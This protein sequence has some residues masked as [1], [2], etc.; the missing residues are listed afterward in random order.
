MEQKELIEVAVKIAKKFI[1]PQ[2]GLSLRAYPDPKS[3][4]GKLLTLHGK[5]R[6]YIAGRYVIPENFLKFSPEPVTIGY[7]STFQGLKLGTIWGL[8]EAEKALDSEIAVR[9]GQ[10]IKACPNL[11]KHSPEKLAACVSLQYNIGAQAFKDSTLAKLINKEDMIAA[12]EQFKRWNLVSGEVV[13][14]LVN[15]RAAEKSLFVSVKN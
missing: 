4:L 15:R 1:K 9:V 12:A 7:G 8:D 6:E 11:L 2:E 14:G 10:V 5:D 3:P 13:Q